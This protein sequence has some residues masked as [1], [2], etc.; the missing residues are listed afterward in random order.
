M[1]SCPLFR[2]GVLALDGG[3]THLLAAGIGQPRTWS[4]TRDALFEGYRKGS[5]DLV[6]HLD[7]LP[8]RPLVVGHVLM[9][10]LDPPPQSRPVQRLPPGPEWRFC[11]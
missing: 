4:F 10:L 8:L 1:R 9:G 5:V 2:H 11:K 3:A 6:E 7:V